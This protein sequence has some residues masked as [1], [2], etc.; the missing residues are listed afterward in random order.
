[1]INKQQTIFLSILISTFAILGCGLTAGFFG[2]DELILPTPVVLGDKPVSSFVPNQDV[3]RTKVGEARV[4]KS[5]HAS[6]AQ[7][8]RL[9]ILVNGQ[10]IRTETTA[11]N[12]FSPALATVQVFVDNQL[13]TVSSLAPPLPTNSWEVSILWIGRVPGTYD[14]TLQ[15]HDKDAQMS[16]P[17]TQQIEVR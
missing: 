6:K 1:M 16:D 4:L 12:A 2:G 11:A 7:L 9:D 8:D 5:Y 14:L 15:V 13:V 17:V 10:R 3:V